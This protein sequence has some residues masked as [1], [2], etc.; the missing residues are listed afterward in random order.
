MEFVGTARAEFSASHIVKDHPSCG[1]QHGHRW[2]IEVA[3]KAGQ[4]PAGVEV[5][6]LPELQH[7]VSTIA[8]E[9]H[10]EDVNAMFP[11]SPPTPLGI[12]LAIRERLLLQWR[13]IEAVTVWA[14]DYSVTVR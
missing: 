1:R 14:D 9:V 3:I 8:A 6:G 12:A 4:D 10:L 13:T 5:Y 2:R 7:A 11:A